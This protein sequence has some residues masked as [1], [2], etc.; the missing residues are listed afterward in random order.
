MKKL[1]LVLSLFF[2][3]ILS[4]VSCNKEEYDIVVTSYP[5]YDAVMAVTKD[6][7]MKVKMLLKPG[8]DIHSYEPSATDIRAVLNSKLFVYVGGESDSEWVESDIL[9]NLKNKDT[10]IISMFNVLEGKLLEEEED[11]HEH[12]HDEEEYDEHVW[13]NPANYELVINS[14]KD[15]LIQIDNKN[16]DKYESNHKAYISNLKN[17]DSKMKK[18]IDDSNK[19]RI[20][21]ADRNPFL[22]F[23]EY[24]GIEVIG[25][26]SGCSS[27]KNVPSSKIVE[28]KNGVETNELKA[29]FK[30]ELSD[31]NIASS[32]KNEVDNDI[33]NGKYNGSNITI[34][35]LYSMQN[36]SSD[37][38]N[39]GLT[40]LDYFSKNI[41][42]MKKALS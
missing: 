37:D 6:T 23:G 4:L 31:G 29:I 25:A 22:Y 14:I 21:V 12:D 15:S 27:D 11:E 39:N 9:G 2:I 42:A 19:K 1:L 20:V 13:T 34:E 10:K 32:V 3:G 30:I 5:C 24:Y 28:L 36:I 16:K 18:V 7:D 33:K 26:L 38:F 40:Y 17:L 8:S 41:E 35:T